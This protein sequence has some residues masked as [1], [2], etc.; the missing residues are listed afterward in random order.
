MGGT[1]N[2]P[3][4]V[5]KPHQ[6]NPN[7]YGRKD[8]LQELKIILSPQSGNHPDRPLLR[9]KAFALC[10]TGGVGKTHLAIKY[11]YKSKDDFDVI[12]FL[13]AD[14]TAKLAQGFADISLALGLEA[15]AAAK[16]QAISRDLVL[17]WLS[18]PMKL[19]RLEACR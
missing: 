2:L 6:S 4:Y 17:K 15:Q 16:D 10:G 12:F 19:G 11:A 5:L 1:L 3:T 18:Q 8:V 14:D 9:L 7:F 13:H